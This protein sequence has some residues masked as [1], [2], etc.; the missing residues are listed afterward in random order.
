MK[1][2]K[3]IHTFQFIVPMFLLYTLFVFL[4]FPSLSKQ[5]IYEVCDLWLTK[6]LVSLVPFYL[7]SNLL[8]Q[9]P[10]FSKLLYP[11]LNKVMHFEN[12]KACSL[13]FL[14]LL[15]G[16][17]TSS[18]LIAKSVSNQEITVNEGNRLLRCCVFFNPLFIL[19]VMGKTYGVLLLGIEFFI[20]LLFYVF[21]RSK[22]N[23]PSETISFKQPLLDIIDQCP[24]VM[25][26]ILSIMIFVSLLKIPFLVFLKMLSLDSVYHFRFLLDC[27]EI[28]TGLHSIQNYVVSPT[29]KILLSSFLLS[30]GG[31]A[32]LL[33]IMNGIKKT[34]LSKTSFIIFRILHGFLC[35]ILLYFVL[36]IFEN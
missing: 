36:L 11:T 17:P 18:F 12:Q 1:L 31:I 15:T 16:N 27:M 5:V 29:I 3:T 8:I 30:F 28:T 20:S 32:I 13:F 4:R 9:Y 21:H 26:N 10:F 14:S 2:K 23:Y 24:I 33:Q 22:E 19:T 7:L 25:L 6:V 35:I 34:S